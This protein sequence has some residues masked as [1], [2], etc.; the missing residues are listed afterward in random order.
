MTKDVQKVK[1]RCKA[2]KGRIEE[3]KLYCE[4]N[5]AIDCLEVMICIECGTGKM[6]LRCESGIRFKAKTTDHT[7][8]GSDYI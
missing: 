1:R 3:A 4:L 8:Y 7:L 5:I 6:R 2:N